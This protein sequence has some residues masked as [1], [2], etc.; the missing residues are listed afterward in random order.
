ML[1]REAIEGVRLLLAAG[2]DPNA[3]NER[4]ET[5]LH[6][7]IWRGRSV[8][9]VQVLLDAGAEINA[10]RRDGRTAYALAR[11]TGQTELAALL[12]ARGADI[13]VREVSTAADAHL[14]PQFASRHST[15]VVR[16]LLRSGVP[17]DTRGEHGAT[18]LHWA[19]WKG[20]ADLVELLLE[21][22]ASLTIEDE[23]FHG[24]PP[25]WF[26]HGAQ[27]CDETGGDYA[28]VAR[29]LIAAG[30]AIPKQDVPTGRPDVDEV[31]R[32]HGLM[33]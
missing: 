13:S 25:G 2:A 18:A 10:T 22:G 1:D 15:E 31:L 20:Y 32:Q 33:A 9:I 11:M 8:P 16:Q 14:L 24:T 12:E 19:C 23:Q 29:L 3:T 28:G 5:A 6:W 26:G 4:G 27:N 7:A 21:H 17:V 30:A